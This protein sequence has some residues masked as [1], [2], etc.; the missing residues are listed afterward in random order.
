MQK[1]TIRT[2]LMTVLLTLCM[3]LSLMPITTLAA[4]SA[5]DTADF[6][7]ESG[8][9]AI[10]L[11]N[12]Y[13]TGTALSSWDNDSK[14]LTLQG[15]K[16]TT[17]AQTAVKLPAG[18]TI[19]LKDDTT[20]T[21]QSG[22]VNINISGGYKS[23]T[24]INALDAA[25]NLT[26]EGGSVG[27][28]TLSVCAGRVSNSSNA[29]TYSS[30]IGVYGNLTVNGGHVTARGGCVQVVGDGGSAFSM[31]IN[32]DSIKGK[33]LQVTGGTLTA[34]ADESYQINDN[35][36]AK[37]QHNF[38][39]GVYMYRGNITVSGNGKLQA[40][41]V[42]A[43][44]DVTLLSN[45]IYISE[46]NLYID[47]SAEVAASGGY[48]V[49][50]SG[51]NVELSG[52]KITATS[53][54]E[55]NSYGVNLGNAISVEKDIK[56]NESG[57]ITV[58][59]GTLETVNGKIYMST[60]GVFTVTGGTIV[61]R[62][63]LYGAEKIN[64]TGG[65]VQTQGINAD[66]LTLSD[67]VLTVREPVRKNPYNDG[68]LLI[69][70]AVEVSTL[71][72]R[73]GTL[74]VAWDWGKFTPSVLPVNDYNGYAT[75]L[76]QMPQN[77]HTV[78]ITGGIT[79]LDT[80]KAGNTALLLGGQLT[81]GAGI[82]E[83]GAD[84]NHRQIGTAP[85]KFAT[86]TA[87]ST[88]TTVD[89]ENVKL[90]YQPGS[91]PQ[92]TARRAGTNQDKYDILYECWERPEKENDNTIK[93]AAYWYSDESCYSD[94]DSRFDTFE[95]GERYRY[96]VQLQARNGYTFDSNLT[97]ERN[98]ILNGA[99]LPFGSSVTVSND[100]KICRITYGTEMR[101]GQIVEKIQLDGAI[102]NSNAGDKPHF[103]GDVSVYIDIDHQRW[104][105]NDGSGYGITSS[106]FWN[107]RYDGK[108]IAKFEAG[109]NY[110]YGIY[111]KISDLGMKEGYRFDKNTK[112]Y[113]NGN[114]ITL[115]PN[116]IDVYYG[117]EAIWFSNVL[118]MRPQT[119]GTTSEYKITE[120]ANGFWAQGDNGI[121]KFIADGDFSKFTGVKVDGTLLTVDEYTAT[122]GST[123]IT[124][125]KD[126][127]DT[128]SVGKHILTIV[129]N[130]GECSTEFE[131]KM[132]QSGGSEE[133]PGKSDEGDTM[134]DKPNQNYSK[135]P[136]TGDSNDLVLWIALI[137]ISGSFLVWITVFNKKTFVEIYR[138]MKKS[139]KR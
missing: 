137:F 84:A 58:S 94:G 24:F 18:S 16:F 77:F 13:K 93:T 11:L 97:N 135:S 104:D 67:G 15:V 133:I 121:L 122:S 123:V 54:Q 40:E 87:S 52:G 38:S 33:T 4:E 114:K 79:T 96:S 134:L 105:T 91:V 27:T 120:G 62:D 46:G 95:K 35:S 85:V 60:H 99:S 112:L 126:Y 5:A 75:S 23:H 51:G 29:W 101:P 68:N 107:N 110:T 45:G 76:V 32:M 59:N 80:G 131:I 61:N 78:T 57:N 26:I 3:I 66:V 12:Q 1:T 22:D 28:G 109:K 132:A 83:T 136:K 2:K 7:V 138:N 41:S 71:T 111:F 139:V 115:T 31:G 20:N 124:L 116:Q 98:I 50:V 90:D 128:L 36:D 48:G 72:V 82:E 8:T 39:R 117:G 19:I 119:S 92:P 108:L 113:I 43:M 102:I 21:I 55:S 70:P 56:T 130:D 88:I 63:R 65:T 53:T 17:T 25:G 44:A 37:P 64:I 14:T 74:D 49:N 103:S 106:D 81:L 118:T 6:C 34:I 47:D 89:I 86:S 10:N 9:K 125:K 30:G 129:Y 100:G 127:L 73:D 69:S 42:K